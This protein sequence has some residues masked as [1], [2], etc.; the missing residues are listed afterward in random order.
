MADV[1]GCT[2][3]LISER[4]LRYEVEKSVVL[5]SDHDTVTHMKNLIDKAQETGVAPQYMEEGEKVQ[6]VMA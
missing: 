2:S 3:R 5:K 4:D 6:N 1:N